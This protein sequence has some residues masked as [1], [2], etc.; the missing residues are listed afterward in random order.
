MQKKEKSL[1]NTLEKKK[2][3]VN[4]ALI[5]LANKKGGIIIPFVISLPFFIA[6]IMLLFDFT[7]L[8]NNKIKL[9]DALEQGALAL[10]AEN[11]P[12]FHERNNELISTYIN[13][14][15]G[16][17]HQLTQNNITVNYPQNI[18]N[19]N[20]KKVSQYHI[21][22]NIEQS[23]L[24]PFTSLLVGQDSFTISNSAAAIKNIP[25]M[26][27]V[28]VTD[29]SA[30][31]SEDFQNPDDPKILSKLD[32]LKRIFFKI[33]NDIYTA[34]KDSTISFSPF[35]WGTKSA[36][37]KKCSLHFM[38]KEKNKIYPIPSNEI[39]RNTDAHQEKHMIAITEN[40]DYLAT[41]ENIGT[42]NEKIVIPLDHVNDELCLY[43]SNAYPISLAK[44]IDD[45]NV[46]KTMN[47]GGSTLVSSGIMQG[48]DLLM[49][50]VNH[51]KLMIILSDGH[52][53]P[54]TAVVHDKTITS[55]KEVRADVDISRQ[56]VQ[57]G[58][59]KKIRETIGRIVFIGIGYNPSANHYINWAEDCVDTE[60]FYM[61]MNT[62]EL[63]DSIRSALVSDKVGTNTPVN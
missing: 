45:L 7:Q 23:T 13:F 18:G 17:R 31:M 44:D 27:V 40:I 24:F 9:S 16:H 26:D 4:F 35:S 51:N 29:F 15:L 63:E 14:Y 49:D 12:V 25:A 1:L 59:C 6:I 38:P 34:N 30:S 52:D 47:E 60:N 2:S 3:L 28:F 43:S 42:N 46:I 33:A 48:A 8:I 41:I 20:H 57:H 10:T 54:T 56:L 58:M 32:E 5:F 21:N 61:A 19:V 53:Y 62:K 39:E 22:A 37:N 11:N 55:A 36:D 50:G